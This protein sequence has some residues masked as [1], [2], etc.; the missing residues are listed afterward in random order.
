MDSWF[1]AVVPDMLRQLRD[2]GIGYPATFS[3]L[4][5]K[6]GPEQW[7]RILTQIIEDLEALDRHN[8]RWFGDDGKYD[9]ELAKSLRHQQSMECHR[10][11]YEAERIVRRGLF[12]FY[13]WFFAL[14]D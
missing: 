8:E 11:E 1:Q 2:N 6:D 5:D 14:W 10:E 7:N 13:E 4:G 9:L 12:E 3:H